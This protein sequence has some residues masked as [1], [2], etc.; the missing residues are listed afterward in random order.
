M[1]QRFDPSQEQSILIHNLLLSA[2]PLTR[3]AESRPCEPR[4]A[5]RRRIAP[6][7]ASAGSYLRLIGLRYATVVLRTRKPSRS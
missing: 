7:V 4:M 3:R 1:N 5:M 2:A 6:P